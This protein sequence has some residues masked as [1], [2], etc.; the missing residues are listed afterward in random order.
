[1][2]ELGAIVA[3]SAVVPGAATCVTLALPP[4]PGH[5]VLKL[6]VRRSVYI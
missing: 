1:M 3:E 6:V 2:P 4:R 5:D